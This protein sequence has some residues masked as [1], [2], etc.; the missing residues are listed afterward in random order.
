MKKLFSIFAAVLFAGSMMAAETTVTKTVTELFPE[1]PDQ[2]TE[3]TLYDVDGLSI[4]INSGGNNGKVYGLSSGTRDWRAYESANGVITVALTSGTIKTVA[5]T[6]KIDNSGTLNYSSTV[7]KSGTAVTVDASSAE[8]VVGHS[9]GDKKGIIKVSGFTI[10]YE[11]GAPDYCHVTYTGKIPFIGSTIEDEG[12]EDVILA[13]ATDPQWLFEDMPST[14][15]IGF[16]MEFTP[17][18]GTRADLRGVYDVVKDAESIETIAF[19]EKDG[20][21]FN[22]YTPKSGTVTILANED[23]D[24][25]EMVYDLVATINGHDE[26]IKGS[27]SDICSDQMNLDYCKL[28]GSTSSSGV[29]SDLKASGISENSG[30]VIVEVASSSNYLLGLGDGVKLQFAMNPVVSRQDLRGEYLSDLQ[31]GLVGMSVTDDGEKSSALCGGSFTVSLNTNK[32]TYDIAYNISIVVDEE[33]LTFTGTVQGI[34]DSEIHITPSAIENAPAVKV[35]GNK[36]MRN[37]HLFIEHEGH[38]YNANGVQVK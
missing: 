24:G 22:K 36:V 19:V 13:V 1:V 34:C 15:G 28:Q 7:M 16:G 23:E 25:Y 4:S 8:F 12:S 14:D 5:F 38:L 26:T 6:Y 29:L 21:D 30:T 37:G 31:H 11:A 2:T 35:N 20:T 32:T 27:V 10:V 9:S 33:T 17:K 18:Q 3:L